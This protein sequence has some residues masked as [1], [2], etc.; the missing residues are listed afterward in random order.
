MLPIA[1]IIPLSNTVNSYQLTFI[2]DRN[3]S[4]RH[5]ND[6]REKCLPNKPSYY[7]ES[8]CRED[9]YV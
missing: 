6:I 3:D 9:E 4:A 8:V 7:M 1:Y 5:P 2:T